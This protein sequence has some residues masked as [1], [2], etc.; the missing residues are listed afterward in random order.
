MSQR[1]IT[2]DFNVAKTILLGMRGSLRQSRMDMMGKLLDKMDEIVDKAV[3]EAD[4]GN[5]IQDYLHRLSRWTESRRNAVH[6]TRT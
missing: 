6:K 5:K 1:L 4:G 3:Q 2:L